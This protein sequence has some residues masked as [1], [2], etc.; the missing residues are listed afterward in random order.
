MDYTKTQVRS[1]WA[2]ARHLMRLADTA[3]KN[4]DLDELA[5]IAPELVAAASTLLGYLDERGIRA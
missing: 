4:D 2:Y 3:L 5:T 1:D